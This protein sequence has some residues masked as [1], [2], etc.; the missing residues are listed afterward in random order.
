MVGFVIGVFVLVMLCIKFY[1]DCTCDCKHAKKYG[2]SKEGENKRGCEKCVY[3]KSE[4]K[5]CGL[6]CSEFYYGK[7]IPCK[8]YI[9]KYK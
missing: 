4:F 7:D 8:F 5:H 2:K 1:I 9:K 3:Y 6:N